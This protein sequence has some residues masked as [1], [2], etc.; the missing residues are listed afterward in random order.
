MRRTILSIMAHP[1]DEILGCGGSLHRH[2]R[3][4]DLVHAMCATNGVGSRTT[5]TPE[6]IARRTDSAIRAAGIIGFE[7][8][9]M[10]DM[11]DNALDSI[12]LLEIVQAIEEIKR[13]I[14]PDIVYTHA[15]H[16]L[17]IDH[18]RIHQAVQVAFRPQPAETWTEI[19]C[20][21]VPSATD[22][23]GGSFVPD[24]F[25][26]IT[27]DWDAKFAALECYG[28]ELR[29]PP[30]TRSLSGIEALATLRGHQAGFLKA[31]A[32]RCQ[33]RRIPAEVAP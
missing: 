32:F 21:E 5:A 18:Q 19:R 20:C 30:H 31:E 2:V 26:D 13:N 1:D 25:V 14:S 4:G 6:A 27:P 22:W 15:A 33:I 11:P 3:D 24:L 17:N 12:P 16:D 29:P 28:E 9:A 8:S 23:G 10:L 7:W